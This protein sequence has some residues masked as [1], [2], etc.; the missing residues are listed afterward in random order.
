MCTDAQGRDAVV[1]MTKRGNDDRTKKCILK[2]NKNNLKIKCK[3]FSFLN[4]KNII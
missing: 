3:K 2:K 1:I 4:I